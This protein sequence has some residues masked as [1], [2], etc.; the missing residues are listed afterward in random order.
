MPHLKR[1]DIYTAV[2]AQPTDEVQLCWLNNC[3]D[4]SPREETVSI[5]ELVRR[6]ST[7]DLTRGTLSLNDYLALNESV[8]EQ[9]NRKNS[10]KNGAAFI[11]A[12]FARPNSR[13]AKDVIEIYAFVLD[14]DGGVSRD[15]FE[16]KLALHAYLAYTSYSHSVSQERWRVI[17]FYSVPCTPE[18]HHAVY[19]HFNTLFGGRIDSR[20]KT[21]NQLWY[22]PACPPDAGHLFQPFF[23]EGLLFDPFSVA[24]PGP[25]EKTPSQTKKVSRLQA[26]SRLRLPSTS[27]TLDRVRAALTH[28][29]ADDRETWIRLG[30]ALSNDL[31][32]IGKEIWLEWS[33]RSEKFDQ[34]N[35]EYQWESF[36]HETD[37]PV[38]LRTLFHLAKEH[39]WQ[40][41]FITALNQRF[42]IITLGGSTFIMEEF[43]NAGSIDVRFLK[44]QDM[45]LRFANQPCPTNP[46]QTIATAW[47]RSPGRRE[48]D[49]IDFDP[50][51]TL[52]ANWYN[53]WRGFPVTPS[54]GSCK[55]F[56]AFVRDVICSG[57][58]DLYDYVIKWLAHM[59]Q[60][61]ANLPESAL[62]MRGKQGTGKNTFAGIIGRLL[63]QYYL[64]ITSMESITGRFNGHLKNVLLLHANEAT[65][66][67]N[68]ASA[69]KLKSLVTDIHQNIEHKGRDPITIRSFIHLLVSSNE[70]WAVPAD[71]DDR[72]FVFLDV[73][74]GHKE[75]APY[76]AAI[77]AEINS[78]GLGAL[79]AHLQGIDIM[80]WHP[81]QRP[82]QHYGLDVKL[83]SA[84]PT[85]RW[86]YQVLDEGDPLAQKSPSSPHSWITPVNKG[87]LFDL[88]DQH[89][90]RA[91]ERTPA[92]NIFFKNIH[93]MCPGLQQE[94]Q[95]DHRGERTRVVILPALDKTRSAFE[96][97]MRAD[98]QVNWSNLD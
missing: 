37:N 49:G 17:V 30:M 31:D 44:K 70:I 39:G 71:A 46:K 61:P 22:T 65:W 95:T 9:K 53:L 11:F 34:D 28:I 83:E 50:S 68:K 86:W 6:F 93:E 8:P 75:D 66:G 67:G 57:H 51:N 24:A 52:P 92:I 21:T 3:R 77:H 89:C 38:T 58:A 63:Q 59:V 15:E 36:K 56:L 64:E 1:K 47:L 90:Q 41:D 10:E 72:R 20:S 91:R 13:L 97:Y 76:F 42:A 85:V 82:T 12:K 74:D 96:N 27:E 87:H 16:E 81:R 26:S 19:Q 48:Y 33:A 73:S 69:G 84:S 79:M 14:L 7:P 78:G 29:P 23:N 45:E 18:Q 88:F 40:E 25:Q 94:R 60:H 32:D 2:A 4:T 54:G 5:G 35:A 62:V 80:G 43:Q 98:G 55:L